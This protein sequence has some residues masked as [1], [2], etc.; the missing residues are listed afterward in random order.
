MR[1]DLKIAAWGVAIAVFLVSL[2]VIWWFILAATICGVLV[3][4]AI[5]RF[6][7]RSV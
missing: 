7:S 2:G 5:R 4:V 3:A 1:E 6:G